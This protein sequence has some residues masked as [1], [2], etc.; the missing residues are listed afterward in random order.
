[1]RLP[2]G[3]LCGLLLLPVLAP[4]GTAQARSALQTDVLV[5]TLPSLRAVALDT[6]SGDELSTR[7]AAA[8]ETPND[9]V[10]N[11]VIV[12]S[13]AS[14]NFGAPQQVP[15]ALPAV[16]PSEAV[17]ERAPA[18]PAI[19]TYPKQA[20]GLGI[21]LG[22]YN[23]SRWAEDWRMMRHPTKRDDL[24]DRLKYIPIDS[25]GFAYVTLS[26]ELRLRSNLTTNPGLVDSDHRRE[27]LLRIVGGADVHVGPVRFYGELAHGGLNGHN[28]GAPAAKN[29]ND[30]IVQQAFG[31]ISGNVAGH[32]VGVRY[33]RQEFTDGS[34]GLLSQK[35]DNTIHSSLSGTRAWAQTS[36]ARVDLFDFEQVKL[37]LAGTGDDTSD[38]ATRLSGITA[39]TVVANAK[40]RKVFFDPF[41]WREQNNNLRW[42]AINGREVRFYYGARLWGSVSRLTFDWTVDHQDGDFDGR[43]INAWN[44]YVAQTFVLHRKG[45]VP[46]VGIHF[47]Y[48]SGGGAYSTGTIH[49]AR[50]P[51]AGMIA[52]SYQGAL[53]IINLSQISP[54]FTISPF[55]VLDLTTE[56][57]HSWRSNEKD[58]IYRSAG[59]AYS[60]SQNIP[61]R[62]V[63]D[64][65]RLQA[66][67]KVA[68]RISVIGRYEYFMSGAILKALG[69]KN[70]SYAATW[71]SF[72]L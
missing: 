55:K 56:Y 13:T 66:T 39:G 4:I 2:S 43:T 22:G 11:I 61:G 8:A 31:E 51:T 45:W 42:G 47:D 50:T 20:D 7:I 57:Q 60:G 3:K 52:F 6:A 28:I 36:W 48:G 38:P 58:A 10:A 32:S 16:P 63:G 41:V 44:A 49:S 37:G 9:Q 24:L 68:P 62:H 27:N 34:S 54:N 30:F 59:T 53:N 21:K 18:N 15:S 29:R 69:Y 72:R 19:R 33:G 25:S 26:G 40:S 71:I 17:Q 67:W 70:S 23:V 35:D 12:A 1:M 14:E 64:A 46:K 5:D 65:V